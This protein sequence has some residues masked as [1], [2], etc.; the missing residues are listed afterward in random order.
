M[1]PDGM[2]QEP[3][4]LD[5]DCLLTNCILVDSF[6][7]IWWTSPFVVLGVSHLFCRFDSILMENPVSKQCRP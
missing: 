4:H 5:L 7:V 3:P 2:A 6:T 1:N